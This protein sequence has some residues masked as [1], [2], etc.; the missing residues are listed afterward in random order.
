MEILRWTPGIQKLLR[1][2]KWHRAPVEYAVRDALV[3]FHLEQYSSAAI[4]IYRAT[5]THLWIET[6]PLGAITGIYLPTTLL[7]SIYS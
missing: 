2:G 6:W 7:D 1:C 3:G 4:T 5:A